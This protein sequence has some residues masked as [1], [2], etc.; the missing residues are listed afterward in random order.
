MKQR[1][2]DD[3]LRILVHKASQNKQFLGSVLANY[4]EENGLDIS[5]VVLKIMCP[6]K[7]MAILSLCKVPRESADFF[8]LDIRSISDYS[9]CDAGELA[10]LVRECRALD[11]MRSLSTGD[12][13]N[14]SVLMAARD[15]K[16]KKKDLKEVDETDGEDE[17]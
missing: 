8:N 14:D 13:P 1:T 16:D 12:V 15:K 3:S 7:N 17:P 6:L 5:D 11:A 4:A 10:N 2:S 9:G